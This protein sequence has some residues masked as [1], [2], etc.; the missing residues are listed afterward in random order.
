MY[1]YMVILFA[2]FK[3]EMFFTTARQFLTPF[4]IFAFDIPIPII[5]ERSFEG[6]STRPNIL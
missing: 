3:K 2:E 4:Q 5:T 1:F 6:H